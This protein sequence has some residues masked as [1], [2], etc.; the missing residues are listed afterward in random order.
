MKA[1]KVLEI[2]LFF[3]IK[4]TSGIFFSTLSA[5]KCFIFHI[6]MGMLFNQLPLQFNLRDALGKPTNFSY[7][8]KQNIIRKANFWGENHT[9]HP[10][11]N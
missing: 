5:R 9:E 2:V 10:Q 1:G 6:A 3:K 8:A 7:R 11:A 4:I